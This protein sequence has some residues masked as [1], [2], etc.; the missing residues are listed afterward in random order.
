M[1]V[2]FDSR[3]KS[4]GRICLLHGLEEV[5]CGRSVSKGD[6]FNLES[7]TSSIELIGATSRRSEFL[8]S[9]VP[10]RSWVRLDVK[11]T[12][13]FRWR[14]GRRR[15]AVGGVG[16]AKTSDASCPHV[17]NFC[18]SALQ[19]R[20]RR[21][22]STMQMEL[23]A[24][25][26][27]VRARE[28]K[29]DV[30]LPW[31]GLGKLCEE[32]ARRWGSNS[33]GDDDATKDALRGGELP[34]I[35]M[36][37]FDSRWRALVAA[38]FASVQSQGRSLHVDVG[39]F[40]R[41]VG[42]V[43]EVVIAHHG[44]RFGFCVERM[45]VSERCTS[46]KGWMRRGLQAGCRLSW[47][48]WWW[49]NCELLAWPKMLWRFWDVGRH[50]LGKGH[51]Q[52]RLTDALSSEKCAEFMNPSLQGCAHWSSGKRAGEFFQASFVFSSFRTTSSR[53]MRYSNS[54]SYLASTLS[55]NVMDLLRL[56]Q[57]PKKHATPKDL[58]VISSPSP[59]LFRLPLPSLLPWS[60]IL[61][62][63]PF[64]FDTTEAR[65]R[66]NLPKTWRRWTACIMKTTQVLQF[67]NTTWLSVCVHFWPRRRASRMN[68]AVDGDGARMDGWEAEGCRRW[69][70][71]WWWSLMLSA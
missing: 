53:K 7:R 69:R 30:E 23:A 13:L 58:D 41:D 55:T 57:E 63:I 11:E 33:G 20:P 4:S 9:W 39:R 18:A 62:F 35:S 27:K 50:H 48:D 65:P 8:R 61:S 68:W 56:S 43:N 46:R 19:Q 67:A 40:S 37:L 2:P 24:T 29:E 3:A 31:A 16:C 14:R 32:N 6:A 52:V 22:T 66:T 47:R 5:F 54:N 15:L 34:A 70:S 60:R 17:P 12:K 38:V 28:F 26:P 36:V 64:P 49:R 59:Y 25:A 42:G 44:R 51:L 71:W 45:A 1:T 10:M 21:W